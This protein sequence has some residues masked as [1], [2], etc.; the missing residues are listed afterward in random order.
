[1]FEKLLAFADFLDQKGLKEEANE[2]DSVIKEAADSKVFPNLPGKKSPGEWKA[3]RDAA[4]EKSEKKL[5]ETLK[6]VSENPIFK[7]AIQGNE[8][9]TAKDIVFT[10]LDQL[11]EDVRTEAPA[12]SGA[13]KTEAPIVQQ[14]KGATEAIKRTVNKIE[15]ENET[16]VPTVFKTTWPEGDLVKLVELIN[17]KRTISDVAKELNKTPEEVRATIERLKAYEAMPG[18]KD[19]SIRDFIAGQKP[20]NPACKKLESYILSSFMSHSGLGVFTP[21][22]MKEQPLVKLDPSKK[23]WY[24]EKGEKILG[25]AADKYRYD[26]MNLKPD[27][28]SGSKVFRAS[29]ID[30]LIKLADELDSKGLKEEANEIDSF[31]KEANIVKIED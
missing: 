3:E 17:A 14:I 23:P 4:R 31:I 1:M 27:S 29:T 21:S 18:N 30:A 6:G 16:F 11:V 10:S 9:A 8:F 12:P 25:D 2:L 28:D 19:K 15:E 5:A 13:F 22:R 7:L 26:L 20:Y 24:D